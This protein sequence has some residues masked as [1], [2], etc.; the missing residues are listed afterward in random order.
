MNDS[1]YR[2]WRDFPFPAQKLHKF[3]NGK[4]IEVALDTTKD[5]YFTTDSAATYKRLM[6]LLDQA[7]KIDSNYKIAYWSKFSYQGQWKKHAEAVVTGEKL[8]T[9]FPNQPLIKLA[10]A[11]QYD[12]IGDTTVAKKYYNEILTLFDK[13]LD[14]MSANN[15]QRRFLELDKAEVLILLNQNSSAQSFLKKLYD[16]ETNDMNKGII[17]ATMKRT[18]EEILSGKGLEISDN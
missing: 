4:L 14:T 15:R 7:L 13:T 8:L 16:K 18:R 9:L 2:V 1:A 12:D 11:E 17:N 3:K 5:K 10:V 6:S